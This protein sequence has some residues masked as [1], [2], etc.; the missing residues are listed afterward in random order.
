MYHPRWN[1]RELQ[2]AEDRYLHFCK[3][4]ALTNQLPRWSKVFHPFHRVAGIATSKAVFEIVRA[5]LFYAVFMDNR[6]A[7][8][9][10]ASDGVLLTALHLLSLA[11]EICYLQRQSNA[12]SGMTSSSHVGDSLPVLAF[13]REEIDVGAPKGL[14]AWRHQSMLSLLVSLMRMLQKESLSSFMEAGHCNLFSLIEGLLKKMAE[15]DSDCM[16]ELQRI[17]PEVVC[18]F[19]QSIPHIDGQILGSASEAED[20]KARARERQVSILVS[21]FHSYSVFYCMCSKT[22][23]HQLHI[24]ILFQ[25]ILF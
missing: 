18:H 1:S 9:S 14:D 25:I 17:A 11:L 24:D 5:V 6:S 10:R 7:S 2:I 12:Q 21:Y 13:A 20:R 3:V 15:L 8:P 22:F 23:V 16:N 19:S 4:S